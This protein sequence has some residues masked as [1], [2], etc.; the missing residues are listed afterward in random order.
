MIERLTR[1]ADFLKAA[2]A[3]RVAMPG[4]VMQMRARPEAPEAPFRI[5]FTVTKKVGN[6]VVRNRAKRRLRAAADAT[7]PRY[8]LPGRDY[9]VI[10]R[11]GT[12][13]R[14]F[15]LLLT[16]YERA[17]AKLHGGAKAPTAHISPV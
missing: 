3:R 10:G 5:G 6:A 4:L 9:V 2:R 15:A 1:R 7:L 17:L 16:D 11:A 8:G 12:L 14:P 13:T